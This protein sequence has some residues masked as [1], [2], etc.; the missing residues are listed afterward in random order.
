MSQESQSR[1][2]IHCSDNNT[3]IDLLYDDLQ[4]LFSEQN[5]LD[6]NATVAPQMTVEPPKTK[7]N[8]TLTDNYLDEYR[9]C[10]L[11][12]TNIAENYHLNEIE[13]I[14]LLISNVLKFMWGIGILSFI[15]IIVFVIFKLNIGAITTS[16]FGTLLEGIAGYV[17]KILNES[18][19]TKEKF[20]EKD[21]DMQKYDKVLGLILTVSQ[22]D[23]KTSLIETIVKSYLNENNKDK[24][25]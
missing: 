9:K 13:M 19:R 23:R 22:E 17:M 18:L 21:M 24:D 8:S 11:K 16:G 3:P 12:S 4:T 20:F 5:E 7:S 6:S 10:L 15:I 25:K 2:N 1:E 14:K